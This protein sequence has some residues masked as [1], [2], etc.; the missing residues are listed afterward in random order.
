MKKNGFT[1]ME[2]LAVIAILAIIAIIVTPLVVKTLNNA[3][4]KAFLEDAI[5]LKKAA[6]NYY[7]EN[8]LSKDER[9]PLL[10]TYS[11]S[12]ASYCNNKPK[13]EYSGKNPYSGNIYINNDGSVE[14]RIYN[15]K[16]GKCAVKTAEDKEPHLE[17]L[18]QTECKLAK[19]TC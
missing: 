15:Q 14:M 6:N 4:E 13:L 2:I 18:K 8:N 16:T 17:D 7:Y 19:K 12:K 5:T 11:N 10:V 1:L 9:L 3:R